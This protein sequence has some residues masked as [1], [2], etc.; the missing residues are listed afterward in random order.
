MF[1][2]GIFRPYFALALGAGQIRHVVTFK[3]LDQAPCGG[4]PCVDTV[5]AGRSSRG[6][7]AA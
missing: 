7:A 6:R 2:L 5:L 4:K 1:G 3:S